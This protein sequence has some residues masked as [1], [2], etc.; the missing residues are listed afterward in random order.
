MHHLL[1]GGGPA[2][3]NCLETIRRYDTTSQITLISDE[4][5]H[6][7]MAIPYW[8]AGKIPEGQTHTADA[9]YYEKF[10]VNARI[11]TRVKSIDPAAQSVTLE[12]GSSHAF[13]RLLVATGSSP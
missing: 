4:P 10:G 3:T 1:I 9:A 6:S 7:R 12:D 5:A 8:L 13:D 11:G 2:A